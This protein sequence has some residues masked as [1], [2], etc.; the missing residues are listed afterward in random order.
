MYLY[1][2][3]SMYLEGI[4][5]LNGKLANIVNLNPLNSFKSS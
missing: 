2:V 1:Y 5:S 3:L 4:K